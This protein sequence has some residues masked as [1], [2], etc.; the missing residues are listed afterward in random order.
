MLHDN[1]C[2]YPEVGCTRP[3]SNWPLARKL[4][5]KER[6]DI[7]TKDVFFLFQ[8][9]GQ[10]IPRSE[11]KILP[12][13]PTSSLASSPTR[14]AFHNVLVQDIVAF[15]AR[16]LYLFGGASQFCNLGHLYKLADDFP[17]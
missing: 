15:V 13:L 11:A 6:A 2:F 9:F 4:Q 17:N 14:S 7:I 1:P 3:I 12:S 5:Q 8:R 16:T 10:F